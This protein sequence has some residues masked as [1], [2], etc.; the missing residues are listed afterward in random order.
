MNFG[1]SNIQGSL[2]IWR[3]CGYFL[4][5]TPLACE[6]LLNGCKYYKI[7]EVLNSVVDKDDYKINIINNKLLR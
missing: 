6:I 2:F 4:F 1:H 5:V 7:S 3:F